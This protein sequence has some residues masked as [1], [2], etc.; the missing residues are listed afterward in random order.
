MASY[1]RAME[2]ARGRGKGGW[3]EEDQGEGK[4]K[5]SVNIISK[6]KNKTL[7]HTVL[8]ISDVPPPKLLWF[9]NSHESSPEQCQKNATKGDGDSNKGAR[10]DLGGHGGRCHRKASYMGGNEEHRTS[11]T[12][13]FMYDGV[14]DY[15]VCS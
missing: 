12:G 4:A 2:A 6:V 8:T 15:Y 7:S 14:G 5:N 1:K 9:R 10:K 11:E 3:Q 13:G